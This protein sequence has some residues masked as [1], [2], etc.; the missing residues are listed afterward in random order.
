MP[1]NN[2]IIDSLAIEVVGK[3]TG[4]INALTDLVNQLKDVKTKLVELGGTKVKI[5]SIVSKATA[6]NLKSF[7]DALNTIDTEKFSAFAKATQGVSRMSLGISKDSGENLRSFSDALKYV[8]TDRMKEFGEATQSIRAIR[9]GIGEKTAENLTGFAKS[10]ETLDIGKLRE[11]GEASKAFEGLSIR[12]SDLERTTAKADKAQ[13]KLSSTLKQTSKDVKKTGHSFSLAHT[14]VGRFFNS[15]K[16]IAFYR[17]IRSALRAIT[18]GFGEGI[19]NLYYWSQAWGT[20]FAPKMDQLATAQQ[21][22]KNGFASMFSPLIEYAIPIIDR[23]IDKFVDFFNFVQEGFARLTGAETWNKAIKQPVKYAEAL[24]DASGSAKELKHQLLGFDELNVL[25]TPTASARGSAG[26]EKDYSS[27]FE[28][29]KT[30]TGSPFGKFGKFF[31]DIYGKVEKVLSIIKS[32]ADFLK[33]LNFNPLGT[34]LS[35]LWNE[36]LS[37]I[38]DDLLGDADWFREK[39]L[40]PITKFLVEDGI[41]AA[42]DTLSVAVSNLWRAFQPLRDGLKS[43]W[44]ENGG[45]IMKMVGDEYLKG[46]EKIQGL[47]TK[48]GDF[49]SKNTSIKK[50]FS[51]LSSIAK[52]L[53]PVIMALIDLA[54]SDAWST[55][56][57]LFIQ[58]LDA[59]DPVLT[60][61]AGVLELLDG[62]VNF[63]V[64][65]M[66]TGMETIFRSIL[67][68][69][70]KPLATINDL[71]ARMF[72][73]LA[74]IAGWFGWSDLEQYFTETAELTRQNSEEIRNW[75]EN[76]KLTHN[77]A[78]MF[79]KGYIEGN[80]G[81]EASFGTMKAAGVDAYNSIM[82]TGSSAALASYNAWRDGTS[83]T[84]KAF[85]GLQTTSQSVY[86]KMQAQTKDLAQYIKNTLGVD[87]AN[88][89]PS[90]GY[91]IG[92]NLKTGIENGM[93]NVHL[94]IPATVNIT[95]V[96]GSTAAAR[97]HGATFDMSGFASGGFPTP[98]TLFMAGEVPGMTE[99]LGTV[100][101]R[102]AVAGGAEI[103]GIREAIL[104]QGEQESSL[105]R[106]LISAV[107]NKDLSLVANSSTGRWVNKA[108]K[109][110]S[111]VTG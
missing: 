87:V 104:Q 79:H 8:D 19:Q 103:T 69:I 62:I 83:E 88:Y 44:D 99:M 76:V 20:S 15:I 11:L 23:L 4:A 12:I 25:N 86:W 52:R 74:K 39:V 57:D 33:T 6:E 111:G 34:S 65:K 55:F 67:K 64:D 92:S 14:F 54:S 107:Q 13:K 43:F 35:N 93:R 59:L 109:A 91:T 17:A 42:I 89:A 73:G 80:H 49:F 16:R 32:F 51:S 38:I 72:E 24:D 10:L 108:L 26:D 47:F 27:M 2:N 9:L 98:G 63:D 31:D 77:Q 40:Q 29:V 37:P 41:P 21:Y 60:S 36:T 102:T 18:Q 46:L 106:Q 110:Y 84:K 30:G 95:N 78:D 3:A 48:I 61:L 96:T 7:A 45:W 81:T 97:V 94:N 70:S 105:F 90:A 85:D 100:G 53:S 28:L 1:G 68:C 66:T 22:L 5:N 56:V 58:A 82:N 71:L 101:G 50:I 75:G